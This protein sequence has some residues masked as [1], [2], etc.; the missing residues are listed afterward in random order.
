[1]PPLI[2]AA[3]FASLFAVR[4]MFHYAG[5]V[6]LAAADSSPPVCFAAA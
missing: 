2:F 6:T 4:L 5:A 1:M 3:A